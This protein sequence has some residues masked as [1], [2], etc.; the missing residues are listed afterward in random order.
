M[1]S[2]PRAY[3][4]LCGSTFITVETVAVSRNAERVTYHCICDCGESDVTVRNGKIVLVT[5]RHPEKYPDFRI[6]AG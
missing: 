6:L 5:L 1:I 4:P 2:R 3:C